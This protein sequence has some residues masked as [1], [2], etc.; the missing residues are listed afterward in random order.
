MA[1]QVKR[2]RIRVVSSSS[3]GKFR[4]RITVESD[5]ASL[6]ETRFK[7]LVSASGQVTEI[8]FLSSRDSLANA[9]QLLLLEAIQGELS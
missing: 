6:V 1:Q 9:M 5:G 8:D 3:A 2:L 7:G 4:G